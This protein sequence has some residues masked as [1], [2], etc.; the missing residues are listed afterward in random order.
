[1]KIS[2]RHLTKAITWR[3]IGT[4]DTF[5]LSL[6]IYSDFNISLSLS[7]ITSATKILWYY[8]HERAWFK[9]SISNSTK[10]HIYKTFS[11]RGIG[12]LDTMLMSWLLTANPITSFQVGAIELITKMILYYWHEKIWY[13]SNFG[14]DQENSM[15]NRV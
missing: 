13:K 8:L 4:I 3:F 7:G 6:I 12:T 11:W 15:P 14:L 9:S 2:K 5:I 1:M 10:R